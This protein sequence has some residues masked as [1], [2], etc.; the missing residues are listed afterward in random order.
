MK[1]G[2]ARGLRPTRIV[3]FSLSSF[4]STM[5]GAGGETAHPPEAAEDATGVEAARSHAR[6]VY[7]ERLDE[8]ARAALMLPPSALLPKSGTP[9]AFFVKTARS[10]G[11]MRLK[12]DEEEFAVKRPRTHV[13]DRAVCASGQSSKDARQAAYAP[14][15]LS[16]EREMC[17]P[18]SMREQLQP[19]VK[20]KIKVKVGDASATALATTVCQQGTC[21][22]RWS[23]DRYLRGH[24]FLKLVLAEAG[25]DCRE[26]ALSRPLLREQARQAGVGDTGLLDHLLKH[27]VD[28]PHE[29][30]IMRRCDN[31]ALLQYW[32]EPSGKPTDSVSDSEL[33]RL[34][35]SRSTGTGC[36]DSVQGIGSAC[37]HKRPAVDLVVVKEVSAFKEQQLHAA[38]IPTTDLPTAVAAADPPRA[39]PKV[40]TGGDVGGHSLAGHDGSRKL[41]D[42]HQGT[43]TNPVQHQS[44]TVQL[45]PLETQKADDTSPGS[46]ELA[47]AADVMASAGNAVGASREVHSDA[48]PH[49][50]TIDAS[51]GDAG[52][53][54]AGKGQSAASQEYG[55]GSR[56]PVPVPSGPCTGS[57]AVGTT[58]SLPIEERIRIHTQLTAIAQE[59]SRVTLRTQ[60]VAAPEGFTGAEFHK[61]PADDAGVT[62]YMEAHVIDVD[63]RN[64]VMKFSL[65]EPEH[66]VCFN[67]KTFDST[68]NLR[69]SYSNLYALYKLPDGTCWAEHGHFWDWDDFESEAA[70]RGASVHHLKPK[71]GGSE[72]W[73]SAELLRRTGRFHTPVTLME[74]ECWIYPKSQF[75][76]LDMIPEG[77]TYYFNILVDDTTMQKLEAEPPMLAWPVPVL[78]ARK[79]FSSKKR[80][81]EA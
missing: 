23:V 54:C 15:S 70:S 80:N 30:I 65:Q 34:I 76:R 64:H 72:D 56:E 63:D 52:L 4:D 77:D 16:S 19:A 78:P 10:L 60:L 31:E 40:S 17:V 41:I 37:A 25:S 50:G 12:R 45:A 22:P 11:L 36:A 20:N 66:C 38:N 27:M 73:R 7:L 21:R 13:G 75:D 58:A 3:S 71:D 8:V 69:I 59:K 24:G 46:P 81:N 61:L 79:Q 29:G 42:A 53:D 14:M 6:K 1:P 55:D 2:R 35:P 47:P 57:T 48:N 51:A 44:Q 49:A 62:F 43:S 74:D 18:R 32:L 39:C 9:G 26:K 67:L 28:V 68:G 33:L 5:D